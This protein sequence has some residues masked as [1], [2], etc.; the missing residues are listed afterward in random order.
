[1][2]KTGLRS[3][4]A[5]ALQGGSSGL[6]LVEIIIAIALI[7]I[8]AVAFLGGLSN[9]ILSLHIADVRTTA[10]S[11]ARS[12]MEYVKSQG[13]HGGSWIYVATQGSS[14]CISG[15]GCPTWVTTR[16]H[17]YVGYTLEVEVKPPVNDPDN[18][19]SEIEGIKEIT[20]TVSHHERGAVITLVGYRA[21]R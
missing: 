9:A 7:G 17:G 15:E 6:T 12:E 5:R 16:A 19:N 14:V 11:L 18:G 20:V 10:E 8:L 13:F 21:G 2:K 4:V 3:K 1:M